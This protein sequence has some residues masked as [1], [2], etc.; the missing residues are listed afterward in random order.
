MSLSSS[1]SKGERVNTC[2]TE[3]PHLDAT[4]DKQHNTN[5][6]VTRALGPEARPTPSTA[7]FGE[8]GKRVLFSRERGVSGTGHGVS[9]PEGGVGHSRDIPRAAF[10]LLSLQHAWLPARSRRRVAR[11]PNPRSSSAKPTSLCCLQDASE[12]GFLL[13]KGFNFSPAWPRGLTSGHE[14]ACVLCSHSWCLFGP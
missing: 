12:A 3:N 2:S 10:Y 13:I 4:C 1:R 6:K 8:Q 11:L 7:C 14:A 5:S 9:A